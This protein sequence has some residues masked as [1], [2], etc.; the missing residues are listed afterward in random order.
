MFN[1]YIYIGIWDLKFG[2]IPRT[3]IL[4]KYLN[5]LFFLLILAYIL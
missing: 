5:Q 2:V 1:T 3:I 4:L